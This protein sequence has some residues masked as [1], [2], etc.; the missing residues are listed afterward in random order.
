[1]KP[2][3]QY[4][5]VLL[6][7]TSIAYCHAENPLQE[8]KLIP[9]DTLRQAI[10][11]GM[12]QNLMLQFVYPDYELPQEYNELIESIDHVKIGRDV[13]VCNRVEELPVSN[14]NTIVLRLTINDFITNVQTI[15]SHL[16]YFK[17]L[18]ITLTDIESFTDDLIP[19]YKEALSV[20]SD[21]IA[22]Q[23]KVRNQLQVNILTDRLQLTEMRNCDAGIG[24]I[25]L[26]PNGKFYL[27]PA[28]YYDE[29]MDISNRMNYKIKDATRSVGDLQHGIQIPNKQLLQLDHAPLCR[30]CDAYHCHRCIWL[31][32]RLTWDNNTPSR[33]QCLIA[34]VERNATQHLQAELQTIGYQFEKQIENITYLDPFEVR[35]EI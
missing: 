3:L 8:R 7:N 26:A 12:K 33:Q 13:I 34:H 9:I 24:N 19:A 31:N 2:Y 14:V 35:N 29:Q 17:R 20:L 15:V 18:N 30:I 22:A 25:T 27:C 23:Y 32:Q 4:L 6:D 16:A 1:M 10:L 28:F 5:V 11:F 21:A